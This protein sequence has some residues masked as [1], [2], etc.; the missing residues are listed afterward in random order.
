LLAAFP[1]PDL[2]LAPGLIQAKTVNGYRRCMGAAKHQPAS[3][4]EKDLDLTLN[5]LQFIDE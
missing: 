3:A 2:V 4:K 1:A 5:D